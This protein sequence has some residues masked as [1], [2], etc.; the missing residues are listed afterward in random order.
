MVGGV[1]GP[2]G[3]RA[4]AADRVGAE[5]QNELGGPGGKRN[6]HPLERHGL[7]EVVAADRVARPVPDRHAVVAGRIE[8]AGVGDRQPGGTFLR[9][10]VGMDAGDMR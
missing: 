3:R 5:L 8:P 2:D 9:F 1:S 10:R 6:V 4:A 7:R